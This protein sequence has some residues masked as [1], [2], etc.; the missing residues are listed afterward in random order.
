MERASEERNEIKSKRAGRRGMTRT[1]SHAG[2]SA[3]KQSNQVVLARTSL[4]LGCCACASR[5]IALTIL[6]N[7]R[8][9]K[10]SAQPKADRTCRERCDIA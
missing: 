7:R 6:A 9:A 3:A 2:P 5:P 10:A 1:A 4:Q 8:C